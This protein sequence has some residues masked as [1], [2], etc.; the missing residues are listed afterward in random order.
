[1]NKILHLIITISLIFMLVITSICLGY[2]AREGIQSKINEFRFRNINSPEE[3]KN[4]S[5]MRTA[6]CLNDYVREIFKYKIRIDSE[7]PTLEEL[8]ED[9]GDCKN[10]AELYVGY[11]QDLGF[12][13]KR[14]VIRIGNISHTFAI[15]S[16]DTGYCILDQT[17]VNCFALG[18]VKPIKEL[19]ESK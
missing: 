6:Y 5:M 14:P 19:K 10:W 18:E 3:C 9:G 15:I 8:I 1:M 17:G 12:D 13:A 2:L 4:I 16:D 7:T 11:I